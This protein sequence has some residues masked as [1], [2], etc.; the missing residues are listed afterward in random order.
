MP[1]A[2]IQSLTL[3]VLLAL[4]AAATQAADTPLELC[5]KADWSGRPLHQGQDWSGRDL[6]R[7]NFEGAVFDGMT[8]ARA[9]L[10]DAN[11]TG[12][13]FCRSDLTGADLH[14]AVLAEVKVGGGSRLTGADL[15]AAMAKGLWIEDADLSGANLRGARLV[16][17]RLACEDDFL[18]CQNAGFD[19]VDAT[20]ADLRGAHFPALAQARA[21]KGARLDNLTATLPGK[22]W[23][24]AEGL[25]PQTGLAL[26]LT[27]A[28]L[29]NGQRADFTHEDL[30][31][32]E[33]LLPALEPRPQPAFA[34]AEAK[35]ATEKAICADQDLA[36]LDRG[37]AW[38]WDHAAH[39]ATASS[40]QRGWLK[41]RDA[42]GA[43]TACLRAAYVTRMVQLAPLVRPSPI[44]DGYYGTSPRPTLPDGEDRALAKKYLQVRGLQPSH[45]WITGWS[46]GLGRVRH[47]GWFANGHSCDFDTAEGAKAKGTL[48]R[49]PGP[50]TPLA[51]VVTPWVTVIQGDSTYFCG[52]RG[53]LP[54]ALFRQPP[55]V[56]VPTGN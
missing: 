40:R 54:D 32:L 48:L 44:P 13:V 38:L 46:S 17:A 6:S 39:T 2:R 42:C 53:S 11:L 3:A 23:L 41:K 55:G 1:F 27:P 9:K 35:S 16:G 43:D 37:M 34:C 14:G 49:I 26:A 50:K 15:S 25:P 45:L 30:R 8:L 19:G 10:S 33:A 31:R 56:P 7:Q 47:E 52:A 20:A 12:A 5:R 22:P 21:L 4:P 36:D 51:V 29:N 18:A 28:G 24:L